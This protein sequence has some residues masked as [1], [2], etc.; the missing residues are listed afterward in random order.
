LAIIPVFEPGAHATDQALPLHRQL[1]GQL[2]S[3]SSLGVCLP[4]Y[5]KYYPNTFICRIIFKSY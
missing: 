2:I 1:K 5:K 4:Q 3:F